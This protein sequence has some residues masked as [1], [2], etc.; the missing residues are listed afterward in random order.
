MPDRLAGAAEEAWLVRHPSATGSVHLTLFPEIPAGWRN[1]ALAGKWDRVRE[2]RR[3]VTGALEV[4][5]A[6]KLIGA[7]LQADPV[8]YIH[9]PADRALL[10][11]IDLA[12]IAITSD[13]ELS[14]DAPAPDAFTLADVPGVGALVQ[15]ASGDKCGRCWRVL[16]EVG[17]HPDHPELCDRCH[18]TVGHL[19][20][21][22]E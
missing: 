9:D 8:L 19:K 1:D 10:A 7:S 13:M 2:I 17:T 18:D 15:L 3:V 20:D 21:A 4:A 16:E 11:G 6:E 5:R 14:A 22:A 12:E